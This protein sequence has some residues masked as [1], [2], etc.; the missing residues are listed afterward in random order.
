MNSKLGSGMKLHFLGATG[1]VTGSRFLVEEKGLRVLV[2]CGMFQGVKYLRRRNWNPFPVDPAKIDAV[3]LT[4][5]HVDHSGY[6]PRLVKGGFRGPVFAT[7]GTRKLCEILLPDSAKIME[8]EARLANEGGYS[9]HQPAEPLYTSE[10]VALTLSFFQDCD[11]SQSLWLT[12]GVR[13]SFRKKGPKKNGNKK[14]SKQIRGKKGRAILEFS[15]REAGHILGAASLYLRSVKNGRTLAFSGDLGRPE[16][17]IMRAPKEPLAADVWLCE[18][19]YGDRVHGEENATQKLGEVLERTF[20]RGG[21]AL[22][23][24]FAVGRTQEVLYHLH[25]LRKQGRFS[26][27][28][29]FVDSPMATK[30]TRLYDQFHDQHRLSGEESA[31]VMGEATYIRSGQESRALKHKEGPMVI[32]SASGMLTGGRVVS[33]L[34]DFGTDEKNTVILTGFQAEGTRGADL[35]RGERNLKIQGRFVA[36]RAEVVKMNSLSAHA[37]KEELLAWLG[38]MKERD[39]Q[40]KPGRLYIIHGEDGAADNFRREVK[41]RLNWDARVPEFGEVVE[42]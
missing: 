21:V 14:F 4:H 26:E 33:H 34:K 15:F 13:D 5:A 1:T 3:I 22:I 16:A 12:K 29:V 6:L 19:T 37:D 40:K 20:S 17:P 41:E 8:E 11:F 30:V 32:I 9:K 28:P 39:G 42:V 38:S 7:E 36:I 35:D 18:S 10:D 24:A 2:D 23:P 25:Q 27:V 31:A